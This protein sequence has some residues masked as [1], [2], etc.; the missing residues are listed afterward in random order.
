MDELKPCPC[1]A[2]VRQKFEVYSPGGAMQWY[3]ECPRCLSR[4]GTTVDRQK[5][6]REWNRRTEKGDGKDA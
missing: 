3:I 6:V 2:E 5:L 1:G 4:F